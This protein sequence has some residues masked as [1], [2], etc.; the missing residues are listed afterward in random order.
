M[1]Q[2]KQFELIFD[3]VSIEYTGYF[4]SEKECITYT[5]KRYKTHADVMR[6][7]AVYPKLENVYYSVKTGE[8]INTEVV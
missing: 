7:R 2:M 5:R 1:Q 4:K 8:I 6:I 3:G